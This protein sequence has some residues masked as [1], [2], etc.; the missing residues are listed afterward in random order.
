MILL[1]TWLFDIYDSLENL[2]NFKHI[3]SEENNLLAGNI[4]KLVYNNFKRFGIHIF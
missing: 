3:K 1:I 4:F 2:G